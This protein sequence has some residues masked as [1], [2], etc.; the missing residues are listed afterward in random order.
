MGWIDSKVQHLYDAIFWLKC[1]KLKFGRQTYILKSCKY[2]NCTLHQVQVQQHCL[3]RT[4]DRSATFYLMLLC[5]ESWGWQS[6]GGKSMLTLSNSRVSWKEGKPM[7][8]W[9]CPLS[10]PYFCLYCTCD[11]HPNSEK[12]NAIQLCCPAPTDVCTFDIPF[13]GKPMQFHWCCL[14]SSPYYCLHSW[15]GFPP[16][17]GS[18]S[19]VGDSEPTNH[20]KGFVSDLGYICP[21][22]GGGTL[23]FKDMLTRP[24]E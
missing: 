18:I 5:Y 24:L 10:S 17:C 15:A 13:L 9:C 1:K 21:Q 14:V 19:Q 2:M 22:P 23:H 20:E 3:T 16:L 12:T 8:H 4:F 11:R 6:K 7:Q